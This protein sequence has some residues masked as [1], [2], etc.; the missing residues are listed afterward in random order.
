MTPDLSLLDPR[1]SKTTTG[2]LACANAVDVAVSDR[3]CDY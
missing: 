1:K 3:C 2:H